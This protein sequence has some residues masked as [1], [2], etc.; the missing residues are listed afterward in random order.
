[1]SVNLTAGAIEALFNECPVINPVLQVMYI[2]EYPPGKQ[3]HTRYR[4]NLSDGVRSLSCFLLASRLNHL[5]EAELLVPNCVCMLKKIS[6]LPLFHK[7]L[8]VVVDMDVLQTAVDAGGKIGNPTQLIGQ[9]TGQQEANPSTSSSDEIPG[10]SGY[11]TSG[12][13]ENSQMKSSPM[14][15][16]WKASPMKA[17]G[18]M[19]SMKASGMMSSMKASGMPSSMKASGMPSSMKASGMP[20]SMKASGMP[21]PMKA[22]GMPSPMKASGM[23]S[24]M[25]A[26]GMPS[27]MKA[28]PVKGSGMPSPMKASPVKGSGM[29]SPMKA[30]PVKGSGMSCPMQ[31]STSSSPSQRQTKLTPIYEL[32][33]YLSNWTVRARVTN[34]SDIRNWSNSRGEGKVFSFEVLDESGEIRITAFNSEVD[35]FFSL[36]EQNKV[37]LISKG[38]LKVA[39]KQYTSLKNDYEITLG[40]NSCIVP[41]E[42][43]QGVPT[44]HC[45]FVP[46][47]QLEGKDLEAIIDVIG[48]C[49]EAEDVSLIT[50]K[51]GKQLTKR[52]LVLSDSS[53]K[54]V[55]L[56]LWGDQAQM[57][58]ASCHPVVAVKGARLSTF[59]GRS[60]A[61]FFSSTVMVNPDIPEAFELRAWY[62]QVGHGLCSQSLT[63]SQFT[64]GEF[65][66]N[67]KSLSDVKTEQLGHGE[68]ADYFSCVATVVFA[69]KE[70]CLYRAC[71]SE[72]C[73]KKVQEQDD[74]RYHCDKC[75]KDYPD[76][77]YRFMLS[78]NLA[79]FGDNVWATCFQDTAETLLGLGADRLGRLK[80]TDEDAFNEVFQKVHFSK[81][82]FRSRVKLETY[83]DEC[84]VKVT[85]MEVLP[86]DHRQH[87]RRLLNSIRALACGN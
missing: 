3:V 65:R 7:R 19:S 44:V 53:G 83:N 56:T 13:C 55:T 87:S 36:V 6:P 71:P 17:S 60:L 58:N 74:G 47:S 66:T 46:I 86:V 27:P 22:S 39:N 38:S 62:N 20:S 54:M 45:D 78:V 75:G 32:H 5:K 1:M 28:S 31:A 16:S 26:S 29:P 77:K 50:T 67:W 18:M 59:G 76:F 33:P 10:P 61:A 23:P 35:K 82:I 52:A 11:G 2:R 80:D 57:F 4:L 69:R 30:S 34:K 51:A 81:H 43:S 72:S 14:M 40:A 9:T 79:D 70:N 24:P 42:D 84:R 25:K 37:Y 63:E 21:S 15:S 48:V 64:S 85:V 73:N 41:C 49:E 12:S 8:L 68:K